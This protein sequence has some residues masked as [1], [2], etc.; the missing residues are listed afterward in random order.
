MTNFPNKKIA[1]RFDIDTVKCIKFGVP[2]LVSISKK[3]NVKFTFFMNFG[4]SV[5]R[6]II[7]QRKNSSYFISSTKLPTLIKLGVI[8]Y[9]LTILVNPKLNKYNYQIYQLVNSI[10]EI[11]LHGG[12]NHGTWQLNGEKFE[13]SKVR[14]EIEFGLKNAK[15]YNI[16]FNGFTSPGMTSNKFLPK[17]LNENNF[18]YISDT[19]INQNEH[20]YNKRK[21]ILKGIKNIDVNIIGKDGVGYFEYNLAI[22]KSPKEIMENLYDHIMNSENDTFI[23]YDHPLIIDF[24]EEEFENLIIKLKNSKVEFVKFNELI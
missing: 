13:L 17:V 9:L 23:L 5:N 18:S 12:L 16:K 6:K 20:E 22:N 24:I 19:F 10:N 3:H 2:K 15:K 8:N 7:F 4:K 1:I 21:S 14:N 11:G